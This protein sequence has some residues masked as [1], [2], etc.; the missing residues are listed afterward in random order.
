[1][2][3]KVIFPSL[4]EFFDVLSQS[5]SSAWIKNLIQTG[6]P[7]DFD[8]LATLPHSGMLEDSHHFVLGCCM[9]AFMMYHFTQS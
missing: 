2:H 1:M 7:L 8:K 3:L 5:Q 4:K 6:R 9:C